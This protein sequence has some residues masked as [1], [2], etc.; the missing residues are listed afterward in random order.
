MRHN[1]YQGTLS[2]KQKE[3]PSI[4]FSDQLLQN[5]LHAFLLQSL[6]ASRHMQPHIK[7][8]RCCLLP[9]SHFMERGQQKLRLGKMSLP[10]NAPMLTLPCDSPILTLI[11]IHLIPQPLQKLVLGTA[12][13]PASYRK[14][15]KRDGENPLSE[16]LPILLIFWLLGSSYLELSLKS[17]K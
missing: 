1:R 11:T 15:F 12:W 7:T 3:A 9:E 8:Q 6:P 4:C 14:S 2:A 10:R 5:V 13:T 16:L 17:L